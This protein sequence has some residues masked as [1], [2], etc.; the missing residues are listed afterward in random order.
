[1]WLGVFMRGGPEALH[2]ACMFG[3]WLFFFVFYISQMD[4]L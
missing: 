1:V 3:Y 4:G 2:A